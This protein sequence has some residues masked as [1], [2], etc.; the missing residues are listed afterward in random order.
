[1]TYA[2][3]SD[4]QGPLGAI[5][6]I[7]AKT[8]V[9][10]PIYDQTDPVR[11]SEV[12]AAGAHWRSVIRTAHEAGADAVQVVEHWAGWGNGVTYV[13]DAETGDT[14]ADVVRSLEGA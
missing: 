14:V 2:V 11:R 10:V 12:T 1:V 8:I 4:A 5:V 6:T 13:S 9:W 7:G 3:V